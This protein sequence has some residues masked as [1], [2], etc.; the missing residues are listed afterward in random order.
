MHSSLRDLPS[1]DDDSPYIWDAHEWQLHTALP[2]HP[3]WGDE[4]GAMIHLTRDVRMCGHCD[5]CKKFFH[6]F[7]QPLVKQDVTIQAWQIVSV[8][9]MAAYHHRRVTVK[10]V[11]QIAMGKI[12][13]AFDVVSS[14]N[15]EA[16]GVRNKVKTERGESTLAS[17]MALIKS[18]KVPWRQEVCGPGLLMSETN[19]D[20]T[21]LT[22]EY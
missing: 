6:R 18:G 12:K 17:E 5:N 22:L 16:K 21:F 11:A 14:W 15:A 4:N 20:S 7:P 9:E 13:D 19:F 1:D 3:Y 2:D 8:V 10:Q